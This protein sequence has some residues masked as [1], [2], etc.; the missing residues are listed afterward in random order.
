MHLD[1]ESARWVLGPLDGEPDTP[2]GVNVHRAIVEGR[3]RRRARRM[4]GYAATAGL[5]VLVLVGAAAAANGWLSPPATPA[6]FQP[7]GSSEPT[8]S[9]PAP[10]TLTPAPQAPTKCRIS[11]LPV[12][13]GRTMAVV[14]GADPTGRFLLGRAYPNR[15]GSGE[16]LVVVWDGRRPTL[17]L[18]R[19]ME[20]ALYDINTKRVAVG[21]S[22]LGT[23]MT[24]WLYRGGKLSKLPGGDGAEAR[25]INEANTAVGVRNAMPVIWP[26]VDQAPVDLPLPA[27]ATYGEALDIDEDGTI[28]G[29][30]GTKGKDE[31][32]YVW[33]PD[34]TG[35]PLGVLDSR[36]PLST[37]RAYGIRNGWV[38]GSVDKTAVRW[39][40]RTG[41]PSVF[42]QF[43]AQASIA[44]RYGWQVGTDAKGQAL[45]LSGLRPVVLPGLAMHKPGE[46]ANSPKTLS[47]DGR[48]IGGQA[49]DSGI[50]RAVVWTCT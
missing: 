29:Y 40:L 47:D 2:S 13:D 46:L 32:P 23:G 36:A 38:T 16:Y 50:I 3:R 22:Y 28:V 25:A 37:A 35:R 45:F 1:E 24:A 49:D 12:P 7:A 41:K 31:R 6:T 30:V 4:G 11:T 42:A 48:V 8:A 43:L 19:G 26:S 15:A 27:G 21:S 10:V 14:T 9:P 17:V 39:D 18:M 44:N 34:R 20:Q 5:T 33:L